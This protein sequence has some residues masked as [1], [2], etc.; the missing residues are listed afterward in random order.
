MALVDR[1][2]AR[3]SANRQ[4]QLSNPELP[5]AST[6]DTARLTAAANDAQG[7]FETVVGVVYDDTNARHIAYAVP[8]AQIML[9]VNSMGQNPFTNPE[10]VA[11]KV[12]LRELAGT[13]GRATFAPKATSGY[14]VSPAETGRPPFDN[15][16][17]NDIRMRAPR[18]NSSDLPGD[19]N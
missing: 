8:G 5:G 10:V 4:L 18:E 13:E 2:T 3:L 1:L 16:N 15:V 9:K 6:N 19:N 17:F 12:S 7:M 14:T 11:W